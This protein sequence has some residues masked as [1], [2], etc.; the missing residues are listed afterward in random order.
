MG[1]VFR[2]T[3]SPEGGFHR[4]VAVKQLARDA[5]TQL[6]EMLREEARI[7]SQL[8]HPN[9]VQVLDCGS[10]RGSFMLAMEFV[11]GISLARLVRHAPLP[12]ATAL[13][14][15]SEIA[16]ALAYVHDRRDE[17]GRPLGLVHCDVNPP[18]VMISAIGEVKLCDFG[19]M[20]KSSTESDW[21]RFAGKTVYAAPEQLRGEP[22][23]G[24][25]DLFAL[26]LT[27]YEALT[28]R[29][30][31]QGD[32]LPLDAD[33]PAPSASR[34][35]VPAS[36]DAI[37]A[38]LC[39]RDRDGRL[40]RAADVRTRLVALCGELSAADASEAVLADAVAG[41]RGTRVTIGDA[42]TESATAPTRRL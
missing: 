31:F 24:R 5:S 26:G 16:G 13:F 19:V 25:A 39:A 32:E 14:V 17:R 40:A 38:Q 11:D 6:E 4:T 23:D 20:R 29:S 3:Y 35:D 33:V 36:V 10:Y 22:L 2:A 28:G 41:A 34:A 21:S 1:R 18:N 42:T 9:L 8:A 7:A 37:V 12:V 30:A 15:A 27:M